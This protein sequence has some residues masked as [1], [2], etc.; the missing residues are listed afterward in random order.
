[1]FNLYRDLALVDVTLVKFEG[2]SIK[3]DEN[4]TPEVK[5]EKMRKR[6][7]MDKELRHFIGYMKLPLYLIDGVHN[8]YYYDILEGLSR[9][10]F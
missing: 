8:F 10:L 1:M 5:A 7:L 6:R 3:V 9:N 4:D 2:K